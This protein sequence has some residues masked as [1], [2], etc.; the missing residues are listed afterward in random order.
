MRRPKEN[1]VFF[2]WK[3]YITLRNVFYLWFVAFVLF[4]FTFTYYIPWGSRYVK[5]NGISPRILFCG[6]DVLTINPT[7]FRDGS[8]FLGVEQQVC[9]VDPT[10]R[11]AK[12]TGRKSGKKGRGST[13]WWL[14]TPFF[15]K[16]FF[17]QLLLYLAGFSRGILWKLWFSLRKL[18]CTLSKTLVF[19]SDR[20][21]LF[22][23]CR[24]RFIL[25]H[26][27]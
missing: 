6:W 19:P 1:S 7:I 3:V 9:R 22:E 24:L 15:V 18:C 21:D 2:V 17:K 26:N 10:K 13:G 8:G 14:L 12:T 5:K 23:L 16:L 20:A 27:S 4:W 11:N 25:F